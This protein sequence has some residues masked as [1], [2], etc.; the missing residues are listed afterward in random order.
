MNSAFWKTNW[1]ESRQHYLDWWDRK[2]L[3][4]TMWEHLEKAGPPHADV[5]RP[6]PARDWTQY[7][8]D[9][10]WRAANLHYRLALSSFKADILP[11]ASTHLGPGSLAAILG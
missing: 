10:A 4:I 2:G 8:F 9:P 1:D 11:V 6:A 3:V 7:W 5:P